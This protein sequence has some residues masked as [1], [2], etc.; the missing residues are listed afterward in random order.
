MKDKKVSAEASALVRVV[1]AAREVQAA[2]QRLEA[3]YAQAPDEQPS[4]LELARF[5]AAMQEL[6]DAREAFD[7][8]VQKS[9]FPPP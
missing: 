5:A 2:S 6:K 9:D 8:L 1:S 3:H 7:A 4:T